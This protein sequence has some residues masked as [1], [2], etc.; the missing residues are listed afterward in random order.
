MLGA[1]FLD[2]LKEALVKIFPAMCAVALLTLVS[3]AQ[4]G[5][6]DMNPGEWEMTTTVKMEGMPG[7]PGEMPPHVMKRCLTEGDIVPRDEEQQ[8]ECKVTDQQV[9]GNQVSWSVVCDGERMKGTGSGSGTWSGDTFEGAFDLKM[10][11][12]GQG[13]VTMHA[14]MKGKRLGA[15]KE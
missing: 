11:M 8:K 7:M 1:A 12:P 14:T 4:A 5:P 2:E 3:G 15:C 9:D 10:D 6:I 13:E